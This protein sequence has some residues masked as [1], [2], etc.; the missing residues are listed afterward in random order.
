MAITKAKKKQIVEEFG[1]LLKKQKVIV[2]CNYQGVKTKEMNEI[3]ESLKG[4]GAKLKALK[5]TLAEI[6]FKKEGIDFSR[7]LSKTQLAVVVG[8]EDE[9]APLKVLY[10]FSKR[11][12]QFEILAGYLE[13]EFLTQEKVTLLAQIPSKEIL[14]GQLAYVLKNPISCFVN[15]LNGNIKGLINVLAKA[16]A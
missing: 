1:Q 8:T 11:N 10:D 12:N 6:A 15:V 4:V 16:K 9:L 3:R 13:K 5:K 2:F 14:L 7:K